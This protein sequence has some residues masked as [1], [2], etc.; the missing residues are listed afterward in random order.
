MRSIYPRGSAFAAVDR[1]RRVSVGTPRARAT[2][3]PRPSVNHAEVMGEY[4]FVG[5]ERTVGSRFFPAIVVFVRQCVSKKRRQRVFMTYAQSFAVCRL[6]F[7]RDSAFAVLKET[8]LAVERD[9]CDGTRRTRV[10]RLWLSLDEDA[11]I[12]IAG[13]GRGPD[14]AGEADWPRYAPRLYQPLSGSL[15]T[16][17]SAVPMK[18]ALSCSWCRGTG[19]HKTPTASP[20]M[21]FSKIGPSFTSRGGNGFSSCMRA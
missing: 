6:N 4:Q 5:H 14:N 17:Q 20:S 7:K 18:R 8:V 16:T 15:V 9:R 1:I 2:A 21:T 11:V 19:N 12:E 10:S 3:L 13:G